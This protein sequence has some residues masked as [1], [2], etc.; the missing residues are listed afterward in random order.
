MSVT[1][2]INISNR[3]E[4]WSLYPS[5]QLSPATEVRTKEKAMN[6]V[7]TYSPNGEKE[8]RGWWQD[9]CGWGRMYAR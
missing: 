3:S 5:T 9:W 2:S 4:A 7:D 1:T 8:E 6:V